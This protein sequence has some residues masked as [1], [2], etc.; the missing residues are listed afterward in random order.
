M[1]VDCA[2]DVLSTQTDILRRLS[3]QPQ[4]DTAR[5]SS[6]AHPHVAPIHWFSTTAQH[7]PTYPQ[8]NQRSLTATQIVFTT[9]LPKRSLDTA[10]PPPYPCRITKFPSTLPKPAG[11]PTQLLFSTPAPTCCSSPRPQPRPQ[12]PP[13]TY[14]PARSSHHLLR[15]LLLHQPHTSPTNPVINPRLSTRLPHPPITTHYVGTRPPTFA[16]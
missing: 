3:H 15:L 7:P 1:C 9:L 13:T 6:R 14:A 10:P 12:Q 8:T 2:F 5:P 4:S 16:R 11:V